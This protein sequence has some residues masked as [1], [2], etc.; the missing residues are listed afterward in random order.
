MLTKS[1][2]VSKEA[3]GACWCLRAQK[4]QRERENQEMVMVATEMR[5]ALP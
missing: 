5:K 4:Q 1:W 3:S 2:D